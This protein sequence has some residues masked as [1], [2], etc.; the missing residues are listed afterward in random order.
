ME[1]VKRQT[2]ATYSCLVAGQS[3]WVRSCT[4]AYGLCARSVCDTKALLQL[5]LVALNKCYMPLPIVID[6]EC[7]SL[8]VGHCRNDQSLDYLLSPSVSSMPNP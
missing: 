7:L 8:V 6:E 4:A 5:Q 2:R 3:S 1:T